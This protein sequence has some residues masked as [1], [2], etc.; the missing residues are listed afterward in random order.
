M[1]ANFFSGIP[2]LTFWCFYTTSC[3]FF[4]FSQPL[5]CSFV[6][7]K[8]FLFCVFGKMLFSI[9]LYIFIFF[10]FQT[11]KIKNHQKPSSSL[12]YTLSF[13][14]SGCRFLP[15]EQTK[16]ETKAKTQKSEHSFLKF[17]RRNDDN[18]KQTN[19]KVLGLFKLSQHFLKSFSSVC[20]TKPLQ[21]N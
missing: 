5:L 10:I 19:K 8:I 7:K 21:S 11:S 12:S 14:F 17:L 3:F 2:S 16:T 18:N 20:S 4:F 13:F 15:D 1:F 6:K 9:S